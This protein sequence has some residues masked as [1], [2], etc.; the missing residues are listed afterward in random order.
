MSQHKIFARVQITKNKA[1]KNLKMWIWLGFL[2]TAVLLFLNEKKLHIFL[3]WKFFFK[4]IYSM[5][6]QSLYTFNN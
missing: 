3:G 6:K 4:S 5:C 1:I 2:K